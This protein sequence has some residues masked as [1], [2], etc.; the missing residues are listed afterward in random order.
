VLGVFG[1]GV[2]VWIKVQR[3]GLGM[4]DSSQKLRTSGATE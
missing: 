3:K 1:G 2:E 4:N